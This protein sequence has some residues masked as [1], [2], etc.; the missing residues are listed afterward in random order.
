MKKYLYTLFII[1]PLGI[2]YYLFFYFS[3]T[4]ERMI[5]FQIDRGDAF[6]FTTFNG[7]EIIWDGGVNL[8][9]LKKLDSYRPFWDRHIDLWVIT[10]PDSDHFYGGLE[11]LK[12]YKIDN[13]LC[14]GVMK[15]DDKYKELFAV[16]KEKNVNILIA[17]ENSD[18]NFDGLKI[19]T[20]YPFESIYASKE[21][22]INNTSIVQ[23]LS[24]KGV[25]I[26]LTGDIEEKI[27]TLLIGNGV[28][29]EADILKVPHH[30]SKSSSSINFLK[31]VNPKKAIFTT[32][33]KNSFNHPHSIV[34]ERFEKLNIPF[35]NTNKEDIIL[36]F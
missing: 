35:K 15:D 1:F 10:H 33:L 17:D 29:L 16:A 25:S 18:Y 32:G 22:D 19:D 5:F 31:A 3:W 2:L 13:I 7:K 4:G 23:K 9:F 6:Y 21:K 28:D 30:G 12:R 36:K 26:L 14:T 27:E 8:D 34:L 24:Y 20:L 11:V